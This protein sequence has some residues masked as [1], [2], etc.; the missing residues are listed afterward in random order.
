MEKSHFINLMLQIM[1]INIPS[2][3]LHHN[4]ELLVLTLGR[5]LKTLYR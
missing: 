4:K 5:I 2:L 1:Y 3:N